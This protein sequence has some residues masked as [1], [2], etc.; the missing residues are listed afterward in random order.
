MSDTKA[1]IDAIREL[2][3]T[4]PKEWKTRTLEGISDLISE[5]PVETLAVFSLNSAKDTLRGSGNKKEVMKALA[6][7]EVAFEQNL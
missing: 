7:A 4:E 1:K 2:I 5:S 3:A 6:A